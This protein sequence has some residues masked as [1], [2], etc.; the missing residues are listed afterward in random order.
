LKNKT[1]SYVTKTIQKIYSRD[2]YGISKRVLNIPSTLET[3]PGSEFKG[4]FNKFLQDNNIYH[5]T[6]ASEKKFRHC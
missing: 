1:P 6:F 4:T 2:E 3:D 5:R